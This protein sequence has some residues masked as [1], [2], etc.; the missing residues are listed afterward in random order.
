MK[1][2]RLL[3]G[4]AAGGAA[5]LVPFPRLR[6]EP[7]PPAASPAPQGC[8]L[9]L[10]DFQP[11]SMLHVPEHPV[12]RAR[13][14]VIDVHTHLSWASEGGGGVF[15]G[16]EMTFLATPAELLE[17][18]DRKNIKTMVNLTGGTGAG[19]EKTIRYFE[20]AA[21]GRFVTF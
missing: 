16:E 10:Q 2:R 1:R 7:P 20:G 13:F 17:V 11:R 14:P 12:A 3:S 9:A 6:A 18:M 8:P 21:P 19:L 5:A 4:L 15:R